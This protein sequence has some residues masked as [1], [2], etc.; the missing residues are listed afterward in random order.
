MK[1]VEKRIVVEDV[2]K[3][4]L[5]SAETVTVPGVPFNRVWTN[6]VRSSLP[7][8]SGLGTTPTSYEPQAGDR[9]AMRHNRGVEGRV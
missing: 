4:T 5:S 3:C 6:I 7:P 9:L 1:Y 2:Y 8:S